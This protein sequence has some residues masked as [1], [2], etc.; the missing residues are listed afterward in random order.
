[1]GPARIG[2]VADALAVAPL[3][4]G[5]LLGRQVGGDEPTEEIDASHAA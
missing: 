5:S 1:V 4:L 3:E 2:R